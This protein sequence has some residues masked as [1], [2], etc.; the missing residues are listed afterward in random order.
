MNLRR[1]IFIL[2]L[3]IL[4]TTSLSYTQYEP[5]YEKVKTPPQSKIRNDDD[6]EIKSSSNVYV[7][8]RSY[9]PKVTIGGAITAVVVYVALFFGLISFFIGHFAGGRLAK[10]KIFASVL[11]ATLIGVFSRSIIVFTQIKLIKLLKDSMGVN[12]FVAATIVDTTFFILTLLFVSAIA[13]N[14]YETFTVTAREAFSAR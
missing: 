8:Y 2:I 6:D 10:G 4:I 7:L 5:D 12:P 1:I 3:L 14:I 13:V 11:T 9:W